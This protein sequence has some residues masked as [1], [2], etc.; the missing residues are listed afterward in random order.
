MM[1]V[2]ICSFYVFL[3]C[4]GLVDPSCNFG[5]LACLFL[6]ASSFSEIKLI[7][8]HVN[9]VKSSTQCVWLQ[10]HYHR[11]LKKEKDHCIINSTRRIIV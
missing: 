4:V 5:V 9:F 3:A 8:D 7:L 11:F 6:F 10:D 1:D 2:W